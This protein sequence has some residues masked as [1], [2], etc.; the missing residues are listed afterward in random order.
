M[1][2]W[3]RAYDRTILAV[4]AERPTPNDTTAVLLEFEFG[5]PLTSFGR[6]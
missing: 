6:K 1:V 2:R 4:G 3:D 5:R